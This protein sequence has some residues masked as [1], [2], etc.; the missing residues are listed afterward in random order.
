MLRVEIFEFAF[1]IA[2]CLV[3]W[4]TTAAVDALH[5]G[6]GLAYGTTMLVAFGVGIAA[7]EWCKKRVV[8]NAKSRYVATVIFW[9]TLIVPA[10]L[11]AYFLTYKVELPLPLGF[12]LYAGMGALILAVVGALAL[13]RPPERRARTASEAES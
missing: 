5:I 7:L 9:D 1:F 13:A 12:A 4:L 6:N 11:W 3:C 10:M 8:G 2:F